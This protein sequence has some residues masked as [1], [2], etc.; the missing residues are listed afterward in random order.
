ML[1]KVATLA[2]DAGGREAP[3]SRWALPGRSW[4]P[5]APALLVII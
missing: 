3:V 4:L 1:Y 2:T 5:P